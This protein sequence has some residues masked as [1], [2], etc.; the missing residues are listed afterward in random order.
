VSFRVPWD[1]LEAAR[2]CETNANSLLALGRRFRPE[3]ARWAIRQ[4]ELRRRAR[5]RFPR[6]DEMLFVREALEQATHPAVAAFHAAAFPFG[7]LVVDL[8]AGIGADALALAKRGPV[9]AYEIDPERAACLRHNA[10]VLGL[11]IT[12]IEGDSDGAVGE[13]YFLDPSRRVDGRRTT[14]IAEYR[15][16]P[17]AWQERMARTTV[18]LLKLSPGQKDVDLQQ[19]GGSITFVSFGGE[20]R[21][22]L[23]RFGE[24]PG[25]RAYRVEDD[26]ELRPAHLAMTDQIEGFLLDP[27][28][29]ASRAGA[30]GALDRPAL[31][32]ALGY[33]T[34]DFLASPWVRNH[35]VLEEVGED[36]RSIDLA[37]RRHGGYLQELKSRGVSPAPDALRARAERAGPRALSLLSFPGPG[38]KRRAVLAEF[39]PA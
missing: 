18:S 7:A 35:R 1:A 22:A 3:D 39:V 36:R 32:T 15:P 17:V 4:W 27:D 23:V 38:R 34:G 24:T 6:A 37:L 2:D 11:P 26:L 21:E 25:V 10:H 33:L 20:C 12:V 13:H 19:F 29:A 28:P 8:A 5:D 31:H 16:D 9:T 14:N 30:L